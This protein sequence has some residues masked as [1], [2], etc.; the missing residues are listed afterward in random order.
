M[1]TEGLLP[2]GFVAFLQKLSDFYEDEVVSAT[3]KLSAA[4]EPILII[5]LGVAVGFFAFSVIGPMYS[6]L[7]ALH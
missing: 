5:I 7:G 6:S 4:I 1:E 3:A 2:I